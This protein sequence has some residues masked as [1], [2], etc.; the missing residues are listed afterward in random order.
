MAGYIDQVLPKQTQ[1]ATYQEIRQEHQANGVPVSSWRSL[2]NVGLSLTQYVS[3]A[4]TASGRRR[5]V[6]TPIHALHR[7][8]TFKDLH[9]GRRYLVGLFGYDSEGLSQRIYQL[10]YFLADRLQGIEGTSFASRIPHRLKHTQFRWATTSSD[11]WLATKSTTNLAEGSN[12]Y[13]T[14]ARAT[15]SFIALINSTTTDALAEGVT[16]LYY[17]PA[18]DIRVLKA[19]DTVEGTLLSVGKNE[20][21]IDLAGYGVGV[22]RG[23]ELYDDQATLASQKPGDSITTS[24]LFPVGRRASLNYRI[25]T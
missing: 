4:I 8:S 5:R 12:L 21:Y 9:A 22:V 24:V 6:T 20:V 16:N 14:S 18:R 19:G 10:G 23:R 7:R 17:T 3:E 15:S 25:N 11:A 1:P 13:Y 2:V